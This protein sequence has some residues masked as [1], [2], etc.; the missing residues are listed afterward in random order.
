MAKRNIP[1]NTYYYKYINVNKKDISSTGDCV[2]RA[3]ANATNQS[4]ETVMKALCDIAIKKGRMPN[5]YIVFEQYLKDMGWVKLKQ[6]HKRDGTK[7]TGKELC[8][9]IK[10]CIYDLNYGGVMPIICSMGSHHLTCIIDG[11]IN[12]TWNCAYGSVGKMYI[13][14]SGANN[15]LNVLERCQDEYEINNIIMSWDK[16]YKN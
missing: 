8:A 4:W 15:L 11:E 7:Y 16:N 2:V 5:D 12:D 3:I 14:Q 1:E 10:H 6:P 13:P 9:V